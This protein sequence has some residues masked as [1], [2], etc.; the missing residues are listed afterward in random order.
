MI[1]ACELEKAMERLRKHE[2]GSIKLMWNDPEGIFKAEAVC[3]LREPADMRDFV[4][5]GNS[6]GTSSWRYYINIRQYM[7]FN[8]IKENG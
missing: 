1:D 8:G 2:I 5:V 4:L 7:E 3:V 6:D